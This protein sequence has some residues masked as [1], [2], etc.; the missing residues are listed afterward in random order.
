MVES[1]FPEWHYHLTT[2]GSLCLF[3]VWTWLTYRK[4][5]ALGTPFHHLLT[6]VVG[7]R[8]LNN[9]SISMFFVCQEDEIARR[10]FAL[11]EAVTFT[12]YNTFLY[13]TLILFSKG[14]LSIRLTFTR[15]DFA[16]FSYGLGLLYFVFSVY[17]LSATEL[18]WLFVAVVAGTAVYSGV[19][20]VKAIRRA[21]RHLV[22]VEGLRLFAMLE[23]AQHKLLTLRCFQVFSTFY[24]LCDLCLVPISK[25]APDHYQFS[26]SLI[27]AGVEFIL[28]ALLCYLYRV[29]PLPPLYWVLDFESNPELENW[30][31]P[32]L[33]QGQTSAF[34]APGSEDW[35]VVV[36]LPKRETSP[37]LR[38]SEMGVFRA[39]SEPLLRE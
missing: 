10:Y 11:L 17:K 2:L 1:P 36:L 14:Y 22:D 29:R 20:T 34:L 21:K 26:V 24:F 19:C 25:A 38:H 30:T 31:P 23:N 33:Y 9:T 12:L 15:D 6:M 39:L 7:A 5:P 13:I 16:R 27:Y 18:E 32:T 3:T 8:L 37:R 28:I 4:Y 35:P